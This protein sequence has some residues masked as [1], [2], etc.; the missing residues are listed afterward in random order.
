VSPPGISRS[1]W[2]YEH[3]W[4]AVCGV[5]LREAQRVIENARTF[6]ATIEDMVAG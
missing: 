1:R 2:T 4:S 6:V 5:I 3:S